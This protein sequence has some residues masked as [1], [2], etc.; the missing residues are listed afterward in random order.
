MV[1]LRLQTVI[2]KVH[3]PGR[4]RSGFSPGLKFY[5]LLSIQLFIFF[6]ATVQVLLS[7]LFSL[8]DHSVV[9]PLGL[10]FNK[11]FFNAFLLRPDFCRNYYI[12]LI[13]SA[14]LCMGKVLI[15]TIFG[16]SDKDEFFLV[17]F[18]CAAVLFLFIQTITNS[19]ITTTTTTTANEIMVLF[20]CNILAIL[21]SYCYIFFLLLYNFTCY[22]YHTP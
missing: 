8:I 17:F 4:C 19:T 1:S 12:C 16:I 7:F 6:M 15:S 20:E 2:V 21:F 22:L 10:L 13:K 11:I 5:L 3:Y 14:F 9:R 18:K